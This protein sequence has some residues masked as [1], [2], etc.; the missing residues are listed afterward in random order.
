MQSSSKLESVRFS[1]CAEHENIL[2]P[3]GELL[4]TLNTIAIEYNQLANNNLIQ[5]AGEQERKRPKRKGKM[6]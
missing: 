5:K 2:E 4:G 3:L 6:P 1:W